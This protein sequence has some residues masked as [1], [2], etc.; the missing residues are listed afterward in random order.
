MDAPLGRGWLSVPGDRVSAGGSTRLGS[1]SCPGMAGQGAGR[2]PVQVPGPGAA[3]WGGRT[4]R[5]RW[6]P[7]TLRL[8]RWVKPVA[9][10]AASLPIDLRPAA[11]GELGV[12]QDATPDVEDGTFWGGALGVSEDV[13][14]VL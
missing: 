12:I 7:S 2:H 4:Q 5:A 9:A 14:M 6:G 10:A 8:S 13:A 1:G 11:H 3:G